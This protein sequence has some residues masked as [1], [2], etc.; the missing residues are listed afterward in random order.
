MQ[1]NK[2]K[3]GCVTVSFLGWLL[4]MHFLYDVSNSFGPLVTTR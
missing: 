1:T 3:L 2:L 4:S